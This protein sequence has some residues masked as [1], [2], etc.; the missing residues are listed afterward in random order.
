MLD[1]LLEE[2]MTMKPRDDFTTLDWANT[3]AAEFDAQNAFEEHIREKGVE[4]I[5]LCCEHGIPCLFSATIADN[6]ERTICATLLGSGI[7]DGSDANPMSRTSAQMLMAYLVL[8]SNG[9]SETI[10]R[11]AEVSAYYDS[12]K[13]R[14]NL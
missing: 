6:H 3:K 1:Q 12:K 5:A 13:E 8:Q 2:L 7:V 10:D 11:V 9:M 4:L 14:G